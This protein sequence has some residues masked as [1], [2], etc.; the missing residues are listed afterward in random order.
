MI[1][2]G[3]IAIAL[4]VLEVRELLNSSCA[5]ISHSQHI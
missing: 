3:L 1:P 4:T 5:V 2:M